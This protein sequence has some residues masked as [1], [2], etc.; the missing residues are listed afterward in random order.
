MRWWLKTTKSLVVSCEL[1][2]VGGVLRNDETGGERET[3]EG[4]RETRVERVLIVS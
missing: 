2:P 3:S 1:K 4:E